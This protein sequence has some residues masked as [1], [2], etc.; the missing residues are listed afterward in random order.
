MDHNRLQGRD[1]ASMRKGEKGQRRNAR[2]Q[3]RIDQTRSKGECP[4]SID[5]YR[6]SVASLESES[7]AFYELVVES[8]KS[9]GQLTM[10]IALVRIIHLLRQVPEHYLLRCSWGDHRSHNPLF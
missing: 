10:A 7:Q 6:A 4:P 3:K 2:K 8:R 1:R 5:I 9:E